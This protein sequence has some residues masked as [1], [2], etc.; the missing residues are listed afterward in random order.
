MGHEAA[1]LDLA[2]AQR[3]T[4]LDLVRLR[5]GNAALRRAGT[6]S[7]TFVGNYRA[8]DLYLRVH[9]LRSD[10]V[11]PNLMKA[12]VRALNLLDRHSV[13]DKV[14]EPEAFP[15]GTYDQEGK[16]LP[17]DKVAEA[18]AAGYLTAGGKAAHF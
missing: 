11:M 12:T 7:T 14:K 13:G 1:A 9:P 16:D 3:S 17:F 18:P 2:D 8:D 4:E 6:L 10:N 15:L 5:P